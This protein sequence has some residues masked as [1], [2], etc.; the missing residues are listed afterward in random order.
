MSD[1]VYTDRTLSKR[2]FLA[3]GLNTVA[4]FASLTVAPRNDAIHA[5]LAN[6]CGPDLP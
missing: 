1:A 4:A 6:V 2:I 3:H 5:T